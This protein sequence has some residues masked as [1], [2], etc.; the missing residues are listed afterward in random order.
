MEIENLIKNEIITVNKGIIRRR[1][2][3]SKLMINPVLKDGTTTVKLN[4]NCIQ[5]I[6][7]NCNLPLSAIYLPITF[8]VPYGLGE[9]YLFSEKEARVVEIFS[10][11]TSFR[12]G[13]YWVKN[14]EINRLIAHYHGC[15]QR[16][17]I[18]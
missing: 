11:E 7:E 14:Y 18:S 1:E 3:V 5:R 12:A 17:F 13:K 10:I 16:I 8:F 4:E 15:F 6:A 9:G 2:P